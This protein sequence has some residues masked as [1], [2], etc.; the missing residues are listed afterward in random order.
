MP[1]TPKKPTSP[2]SSPRRSPRLQELPSLSNSKAKDKE[3]QKEKSQTNPGTNTT[4]SPEKKALEN[5]K[6]H[7]TKKS[8]D[9]SVPKTAVE[10]SP[11]S[12]SDSEESE[13]ES[14]VDSDPHPQNTNPDTELNRDDDHSTDDDSENEWTDDENVATEEDTEK[15]KNK[16][17]VRFDKPYKEAALRGK[18]K[19]PQETLYQQRRLAVMIN[20]PEVDNN[21]DRLSHLVREIN[22]FI[23]FARKNNSKFRLR[24]FDANESPKG[25]DKNQWRTRMINNDSADFRSYCQGYFP[26]TPPRGGSYRL[27]I[28]AVFDKKVSLSSLIENVTHDWGNQDGRSISDIKSQMI[29]DPVKI[30]YFMRATRYL[31]HSYELLDALEWQASQEGQDVKFGISW[32][33][34]PSPVGGYDKNTAVQAV[35]IETNKESKIEATELLKK[36]YPLNPQKK[37]KPPYPGNFRFVINKDHPSVKGNNIAI[38]NLSVLMERQGIF[39]LDTRAEQTYCIKA[40]DVSLPGNN[41]SLRH[42]LL[43]IKSTTSGKDWA[44]KNLFLSVSKSINSR[45]GQKSSWFTFHKAVTEEASSIVKNLPLFMKTEWGIDPEDCCFAQFLN[46]RDEWDIK[47][48]VANNE[49]TEELAKATEEYTIDLKRE[50]ENTQLQ[51]DISMTSKAAREMKRMMGEGDETIASI[52]KERQR[53][54]SKTKVPQTPKDINIDASKSIGTLSAISASSTKTSKVR[55]RLNKEYSER[56]EAQNHQ[57]EQLLE[58]KKNQARK[59]TELQLQMD[60]MTAMLKTLQTKPPQSL[61]SQLQDETSQNSGEPSGSDTSQMSHDGSKINSAKTSS[62][63]DNSPT[64]EQVKSETPNPLNPD[65][66]SDEDFADGEEEEYLIFKDEQDRKEAQAKAQGKTF[67]RDEWKG[68]TPVDTPLPDTSDEEELTPRKHSRLK[69]LIIT[70]SDETEHPPNK[71]YFKT[72]RSDRQKKR[73]NATGSIDSGEDG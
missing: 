56:F 25:Q 69:R 45:T 58:D 41:L 18:S 30:G 68:S 33:T 54:T 47:N 61:F 36:W 15:A 21:V 16:G 22:E 4:E 49:D 64:E 53:K 6:K 27:R 2:K 42:R 26:F 71:E 60:Q 7:R 38:A 3:T 59:A 12:N 1:R 24:P 51:D 46:D 57:I 5:Q 8:K 28:N 70:A 13:E 37:A 31:T 17:Q 14:S 40:L 43:Q 52:S 73:S 29:Y 48:R 65:Y 55:A 32:G 63:K 72:N 34:I 23:K 9:K 44:G 67:T 11:A 39:N 50:K 35:I 19:K 66:R 10:P 20:I 62:I